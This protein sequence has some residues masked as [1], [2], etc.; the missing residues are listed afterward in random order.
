[1]LP[2]IISIPHSSAQ[3][4]EKIRE[5]LALNEQ[6]I[7]ESVDFG[8][9]EIFSALP[10]HHIFKA[11]WSRLIV[12]LNRAPDQI[13]KKGV[14]ALTDY[15]GR[16]IYKPGRIPDN[17]SIIARVADFHRPYHE[18]LESAL[19]DTRVIGLID[20]HSLNGTG[21]ADAPDPG[22]RRKDIIISNNGDLNG[23]PRL[24]ASPTS[25]TIDRIQQFK[26]AFQQ[27]G[28]SVELNSPYLGGYITHH[29]GRQLIKQ[30]KF[31]IQIEMNQDLYM[32]PKSLAPDPRLVTSIAQQVLLALEHV[33]QDF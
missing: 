4:P 3:I 33:G 5:S 17:D 21:P 25:C 29:Y 20:G 16:P 7:I 18:K 19:A 1:M 30:G 10:S 13:D 15:H 28:F 6:Q 27:Q 12:D 2:L 32:H 22:Q 8:A 24:G 11:K 14:V 26:Q 23:A 9:E 31:A